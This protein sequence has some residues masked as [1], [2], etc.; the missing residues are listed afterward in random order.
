MLIAQC[1]LV[2]SC[3]IITHIGPIVAHEVII[4][5]S[6]RCRTCCFVGKNTEVVMTF[7]LEI[8]S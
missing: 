1:G 6:L 3:H 4:E 5:N 8:C 7:V 2:S